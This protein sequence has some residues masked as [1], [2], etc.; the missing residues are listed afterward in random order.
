M[1]YTPGTRWGLATVA[2]VAGAL[3]TA[4]SGD[5]GDKVDSGLTKAVEAIGAATDSAAGR[6]AGAEYT[7]AQLTAFLNTYNDAEI[8][9]GQ[10]AQ[11]KATD[12]EVRSFAQSL[13]TEHRALKTEVS[14]T[15]QRLGV[16]PALEADIENVTERHQE[17]MQELN[18]KA[19]GRPFDEAF[20]EHEIRMH[21]AVLDEI[22]DSLGRNRNP[23]L[24]P[25]LEKARDGIKAHLAKAEQLEK[26][27]SEG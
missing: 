11:S 17:A 6:L 15:A 1:R 24:K 23:E 5:T 10:M 20:L 7:N 16:T 19:A 25:L 13:V 14:S 3:L 4:C 22:E 8:E 12:P 18:A 9:M 21:K 2:A 27:V 26:K